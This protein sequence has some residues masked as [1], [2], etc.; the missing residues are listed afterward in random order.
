MSYNSEWNAKELLKV[1]I[2]NVSEVAYQC[3][4]KDRIFQLHLSSFMDLQP[5]S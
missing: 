2:L 1:R 3:G 4:Y 5:C